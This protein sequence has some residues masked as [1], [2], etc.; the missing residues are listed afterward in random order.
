MTLWYRA[1]EL[2]FGS[3]LYHTAIDMW[4][5]G[6]IF[7]ELLKQKPLFPAKNEIDAIQRIYELLGAPNHHIWPNYHSLP[8]YKEMTQQIEMKKQYEYNQIESMF[9]VYKANCLDLM[10]HLLAYDPSKRI[11]ATNAIKHPFF[12]EMPMPCTVDMMPTFP[13]H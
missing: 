1:P 8:K 10:K 3:N 2:L 4:A 6:C 9:A 12:K 11:T 13:A 5:I 7:A